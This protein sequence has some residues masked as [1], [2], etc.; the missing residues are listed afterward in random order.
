MLTRNH[1][2]AH[3]RFF[4]VSIHDSSAAC[5]R[6]PDHIHSLL[7]QHFHVGVPIASVAIPCKAWSFASPHPAR[8]FPAVPMAQSGAS[9]LTPPRGCT[10]A[11]SA[12]QNELVSRTVWWPKPPLAPSQQSHTLQRTGRSTGGTPGRFAFLRLTQVCRTPDAVECEHQPQTTPAPRNNPPGQHRRRS[13]A[14]SSSYMTQHTACPW[15]VDCGPPHFIY[16]T[17]HHSYTVPRAILSRHPRHC[18]AH[19]ICMAL[20][21][22][23]WYHTAPN[24]RRCIWVRHHI[25]QPQMRALRATD[26]PA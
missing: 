16:R 24:R 1:K 6:N 3:A 12:S 22:A 2:C 15:T 26:G 23:Q 14:L 7:E 9:V 20:A 18:Q 13:H 11:C 17:T 25:D 4:A 8:K 5:H 21:W 19:A 10:H